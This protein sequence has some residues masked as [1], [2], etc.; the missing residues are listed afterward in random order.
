MISDVSICISL[1][2]PIVI[3][4]YTNL[5]SANPAAVFNLNQRQITYL[6]CVM[7]E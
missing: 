7:H 3:D 4:Y 1:L 5:A 2:E 6:M